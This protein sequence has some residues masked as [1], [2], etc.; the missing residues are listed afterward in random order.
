MK[1]MRYWQVQELT[2]EQIECDLHFLGF[3]IMENKLKEVTQQTIQ[4]LNKCKIRTIMATGDNTLTAISVGRECNILKSDQEVYFGDVENQSI[5]WK[6]SK[7]LQDEILEDEAVNDTANYMNTEQGVLDAYDDSK[8]VPWENNFSNDYGVALN[9]KTLDFMFQN[10]EKYSQVLEKVLYKAQVYARMSPDDKANLVELLQDTMK[11]QVG[12][13][14]DGANDC[15][16]L[17]QADA[18]LSLSEAE[19]SIAA[20]FTSQVQDISCIITLL[21]EGRAAL[22]TT[23]QAFKFIELYSMIQFFSVTLLYVKGS[24]L[25]DNQYLYI[26]IAVLVPLCVFQSWTGAYH[27]LTPDLPQESLFSAPVLLSV[28]GSAVIQFSFQIY[29]YLDVHNRTGRG[30]VKCVQ[31]KDV[32]ADDPPC[33][34]NTV[35][36]LFTTMQYTTTCLCFSISKPFRKPIY[37]NP[38]YFVSVILMLA[39]QSW[40]ILAMDKWDGEIFATVSLPQDYRYWILSMVVINSACSYTFEKF[41]IGMFGRYWQRRQ[42]RL[43]DNKAWKDIDASARDFSYAGGSSS[44]YSQKGVRIPNNSRLRNSKDE[45]IG[46]QEEAEGRYVIEKSQIK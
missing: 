5:V 20:P 44:Q 31:A 22:T 3:L 11:V 13:C 30:Y 32:E 28:L 17:K 9:G 45:G 25:S 46:N 8:T 16:A 36:Y 24:N 42:T 40:L 19:A 33:S 23:F 12:M 35:M 1:D 41:V 34:D 43:A 18:G 39:Y 10:K 15:G 7:G 37:S 38:L 21:R 2:R 14:G 26:D 6:S 4:T 29:M 27:K